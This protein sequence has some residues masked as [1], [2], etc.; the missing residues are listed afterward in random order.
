[1]QT[2]LVTDDDDN[3]IYSID[4]DGEPDEHVGKLYGKNKKPHFF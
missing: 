3:D 2:Y 4:N 1:M